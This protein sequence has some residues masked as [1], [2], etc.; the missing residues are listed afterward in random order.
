MSVWKDRCVSWSPPSICLYLTIVFSLMFFPLQCRWLTAFDGTLVFTIKVFP[1]HNVFW[2][3]TRDRHFLPLYLTRFHHCYNTTLVSVSVSL[4]LQLKSKW[5]YKERPLLLNEQLDI[6]LYKATR[7]HS[8]MYVYFVSEW[9]SQ[10]SDQ[11]RWSLLALWCSWHWC[12]WT[13]Q[14]GMRTWTWQSCST[15]TGTPNMASV[16]GHWW[17]VLLLFMVLLPKV[18]VGRVLALIF[19]F[20]SFEFQILVSFFIVQRIQKKNAGKAKTL[21]SHLKGSLC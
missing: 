20:W 11:K 14:M 10:C 16:G 17:R 3:K 13:G 12:L 5:K 15:A 18:Q 21:L 4:S 9:E 1:L 8:L 2:F 7:L 6:S 19:S